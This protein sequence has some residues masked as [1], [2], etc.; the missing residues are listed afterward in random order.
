MLLA[1]FKKKNIES[2]NGAVVIENDDKMPSHCKMFLLKWVLLKMTAHVL[3]TIQRKH[4]RVT[5]VLF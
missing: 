4:P 1:S 3:D 2:K 5:I